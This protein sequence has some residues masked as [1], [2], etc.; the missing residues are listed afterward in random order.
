MLRFLALAALFLVLSAACGADENEGSVTPTSTAAPSEG[1]TPTALPTLVSAQPPAATP[2]A[3]VV[4]RL[5]AD[6]AAKLGVAAPAITVVSLEPFVWPDG[7]LGLGGPGVVCTQALVPGW[8]AV[9]RGPDGKEY[10][11]RGAGDRFA[12]E[13]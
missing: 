7:C 11:Y 8:L 2:A 9:L 12:R 1:P 10:R 6:L 13:P 3:A 5:K 4:D